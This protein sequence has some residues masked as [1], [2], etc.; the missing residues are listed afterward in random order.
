MLANCN[1]YNVSPLNQFA[2]PAIS[3]ILQIRLCQLSDRYNDHTEI[4]QAYPEQVFF[5]TFNW[6]NFPATMPFAELPNPSILTSGTTSYLVETSPTLKPVVTYN[7]PSTVTYQTL[8]PVVENNPPEPKTDAGT[9][10]DTPQFCK[11]ENLCKWKGSVGICN[12]MFERLDMLKVH[13][14]DH[15]NQ[16]RKPQHEG[17]KSFVCRW[18]DCKYSTPILYRFN[19]HLTKH[20]KCIVPCEWRESNKRN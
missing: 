14:R 16:A 15:N 3:T 7:C 8:R 12:R 10:D 18:E 2:L 9:S 5:N 19:R 11:S 1:P 4:G 17:D 6:C 20:V 13:V